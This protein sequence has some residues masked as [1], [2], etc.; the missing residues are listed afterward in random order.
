MAVILLTMTL[1][2]RDIK[3]GVNI[4]DTCGR[5]TYALN[6]S[7]EYIRSSLNT[8]DVNQYECSNGGGTPRLKF[9][10]TGPILGVVGGSYSSVS[11]QVRIKDDS[12]VRILY[13]LFLTGSKPF[14]TLSHSPNIASLDSQGTQ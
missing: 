8:F 4:L 6:Q 3:L 14:K 7:L 1:I 5:D 9:N 12:I 10:S 2:F 11:I 13:F